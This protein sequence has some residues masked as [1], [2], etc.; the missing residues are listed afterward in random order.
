MKLKRSEV[1]F[2]LLKIYFCGIKTIV[3]DKVVAT[4]TRVG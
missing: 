2:F 3:N 1:L 4:V